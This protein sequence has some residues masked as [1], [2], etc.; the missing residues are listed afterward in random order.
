MKCLRSFPLVGNSD[1][2]NNEPVTFLLFDNDA[3]NMMHAG[4][5]FVGESRTLIF[6]MVI[7]IR[8]KCTSKSFSLWFLSI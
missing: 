1:E 3:L 7:Q 6:I 4:W 8:C 2:V 5:A